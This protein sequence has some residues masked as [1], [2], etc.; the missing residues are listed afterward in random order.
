MNILYLNN[1]MTI[2]GVAKCILKL[3]KELKNDNKIIIASKAGGA[4]LPEFEKLGIINYPILDVENKA[5]HNIILNIERL[6]KLVNEQKIDII[7]SHHRM[8]TLIAKVVSKFTKVEVI[9]TQ[10]L[11]IENKFK[12]TKLALSN[13]SIITVSEAAKRILIQKSRLKDKNIETIYNTIET[14]SENKEVDYELIK[15]KQ[16]GYFIV[17]QVSRIVDYKG[18]Y[19]FV[20]V[21][22][23]TTKINS[24]IKFVLLGDGPELNNIREIVKNEKLENDIYLLGSKDNIIEHLKYIDILILCSYIEGLPLAPLEAFSQGVPVVATNIDGT[25]E[26]I[27]NGYNGYLV[28]MKDIES[29][30]ENIL[31]LYFDKDTFVKMKKNAERK[32]KEFFNSDVYISKHVEKYKKLKENS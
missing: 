1:E 2:G 31:R 20:E 26:E 10:H 16:N 5:P 30:K 32:Y 23:R 24:M 21:A 9:H 27:V 12:L 3:S 18:V 19:D 4:L 17:A 15:L 6:I 14:Y 28:E 13:I 7:H 22:K 29:F 8:T 11:C 25:N